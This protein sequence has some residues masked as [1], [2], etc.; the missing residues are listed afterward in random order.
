MDLAEVRG[1]VIRS[2]VG[3]NVAPI[4]VTATAITGIGVR[5]ISVRTRTF[6]VALRLDSSQV[7]PIYD[8]RGSW[9]KRQ[10]AVRSARL[11]VEA[12]RNNGELARTALVRGGVVPITPSLLTSSTRTS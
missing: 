5:A 11:E 12:C 7:A 8:T 1:I 4:Q 6:T 10:D 2:D 9:R 3:T